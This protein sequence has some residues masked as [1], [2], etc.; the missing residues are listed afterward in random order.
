MPH[1]QGAHGGAWL[2]PHQT[3]GAHTHTPQGWHRNQLSALPPRG[4]ASA[5]IRSSCFVSVHRPKARLPAEPII[6]VLTAR[7]GPGVA[8]AA[9]DS[10]GVHTGWQDTSQSHMSRHTAECSGLTYLTLQLRTRSQGFCSN[11]WGAD[12]A[13]SRAVAATEQR[14]GPTQRD[15]ASS[16]QHRT[17]HTLHQGRVTG[18]TCWGKMWQACIPNTALTS[19][20]L[21]SHSPPQNTPTGKQ[22]FK[23]TVDNFLLNSWSKRN[24]SKTKMQ[25]NCCCCC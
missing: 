14:G 10:V 22:P 9:A 2:Q 23:I 3:L 6:S 13:P 5:G 12:P 4:T 8:P 15:S 18:G 25:R 24:I 1:S 19:K 17:K 20:R 11:N 21:D 7:T 16:G